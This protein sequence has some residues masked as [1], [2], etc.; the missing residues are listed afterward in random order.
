MSIE[1]LVAEG[2]MFNGGSTEAQRAIIQ[3]LAQRQ[4]HHGLPARL[5]TA[6]IG[7]PG[8]QQRVV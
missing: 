5:R 7:N 8:Q 2:D 1:Q 3:V 6:G 4:E